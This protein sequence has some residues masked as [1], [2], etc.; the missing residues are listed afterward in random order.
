MQIFD[1]TGKSVSTAEYGYLFEGYH[2]LN[3]N[4]SELG[5]GLYIVKINSGSGSFSQRLSIN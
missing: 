2:E 4:L 3:V 1:M 5:S